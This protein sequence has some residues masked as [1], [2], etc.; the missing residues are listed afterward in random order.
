MI[1]VS[2]EHVA[3]VVKGHTLNGKPFSECT[4]EEIRKEWLAGM[5]LEAQDG[6]SEA[7]SS[8][9]SALGKELDGRPDADLEGP[10]DE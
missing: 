6:L 3:E 2:T 10:D 4:T 5:W 1:D 9:M 7:Q 8:R